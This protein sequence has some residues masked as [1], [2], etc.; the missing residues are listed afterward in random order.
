MHRYVFKTL[1]VICSLS[2]T[3]ITI[4]YANNVTAK[5]ST[6]TRTLYNSSS[7]EKSSDDEVEKKKETKDV[8]QKKADDQAAKDE[9]TK[10][11]EKYP[12]NSIDEAYMR[13]LA[14]YCVSHWEQQECLKTLSEISL[15]VTSNYAD[16]LSN[17]GHAKYHEPLK[18]KCAAATAATRMEVPGYAMLSAVTE[19]LNI[20]VDINQ[21]TS[22]RPDP[23]KYQLM[24]SGVLCLQGDKTCSQI[25]GALSKR[26][27]H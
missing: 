21:A 27:E 14:K 2:L 10:G 17:A 18:Q 3:S 11:M 20:I 5:K 26:L 6:S 8:E 15:T 7:D 4:A 9:K 13:N 1:L 24:V 19:C 22:V 16:S 12:V 25:E 23:T